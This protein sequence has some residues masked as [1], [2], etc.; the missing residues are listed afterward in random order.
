MENNMDR[1]KRQIFLPSGD[2]SIKFIKEEMVPDSSRSQH[3]NN[4]DEK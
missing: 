2:L 1:N 3:S 4:Y